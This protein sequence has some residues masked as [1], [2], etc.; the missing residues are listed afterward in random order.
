MSTYTCIMKYWVHK[1]SNILHI[2]IGYVQAYDI[3]YAQGSKSDLMLK[4]TRGWKI[5]TCVMASR[6]I[7]D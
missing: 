3:S 2:S 1:I 4:G 6:G 7:G 5:H